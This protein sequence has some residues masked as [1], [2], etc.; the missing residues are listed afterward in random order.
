MK[1]NSAVLTIE[2]VGY[3]TGGT[4]I[5]NNVSFSLLPG[6]FRLITGPSGCG[7]STLLKII[8]SLLTPTSGKIFFE[9]KDISTLSPEAY[10]QQV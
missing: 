8:A 1:D 7:K 3:R 2:D 10:R 6:E 9:G 5:L 4:T